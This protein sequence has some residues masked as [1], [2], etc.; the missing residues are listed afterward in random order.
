MKKLKL[1]PRICY[2]EMGYYISSPIY[3]GKDG[4]YLSHWQQTSP[5]YIKIGNLVNYIKSKITDKYLKDTLIFKCYEY[6]L[7]K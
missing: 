5:Y 6:K 7:K 2:S 1:K 4:N 3:A